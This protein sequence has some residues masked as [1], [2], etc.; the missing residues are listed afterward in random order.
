MA[1]PKLASGLFAGRSKRSLVMAVSVLILVM[2]ALFIAGQLRPVAESRIVTALKAAGFS[3]IAIGTISLHPNGLR[4]SNITLDRYGFDTIKTLD[5]EFSWPSFIS[6]GTISRMEIKDVVLNR[7]NEDV[8]MAGQNLAARLLKLPDHRISVSNAIIDLDTGFGG[9]RVLLDATAEPSGNGEHR[10]QSNIR[11]DQYQ[12]GFNSTWQGTLQKDGTLDLAG[13]LLDGRLNLGPLRMSRFNGWL[14]ITIDSSGYNLQSQLQAGSASFMGIPLQNV[15]VVN[16]MK[17]KQNDIIVRSG[18]SGIPDILFT[19][20]AR[21]TDKEQN[22]QAILKGNNFGALMDHIG[23]LKKN[24]QT[25]GDPLLQLRTFEMT[26]ELQPE[27][28]FVGGPMP[29][30]IAL[31]ADG[32]SIL[33]GNIL[34]YPDTLDI[35]GSLETT[36]AI[37]PALQDYFKIPSKN[38]VQNFIR[39]DGDAREFLGLDKNKT[40]PAPH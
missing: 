10:I 3:Q 27:K 12:L 18:I 6:N 35:R 36:A 15:S 38:I 29:F 1:L 13:T 14:G 7:S 40:S 33:D 21:R 30:G 8:P 2:A 32:Q 39:L 9:I 24:R 28:R 22:F 19:A 23:E 31:I 17:P 37:A 34:L 26:L 11:A 4:A 20:D 16:D 5:V 25:I